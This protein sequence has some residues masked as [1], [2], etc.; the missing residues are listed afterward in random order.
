MVR[1]GKMALRRLPI[2]NSS[3]APHRP[4]DNDVQYRTGHANDDEVDDD[5]NDDEVEIFD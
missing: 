4:L 2:G 5:A 3:L 1:I